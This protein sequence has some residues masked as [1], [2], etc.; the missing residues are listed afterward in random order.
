MANSQHGVLV[1]PCSM[2]TS[3]VVTSHRYLRSSWG[4]LHLTLQQLSLTQLD[5][6]H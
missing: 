5:V 2:H 1:C 4:Q 6:L 3:S